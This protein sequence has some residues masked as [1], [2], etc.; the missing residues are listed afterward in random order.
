MPLQMRE[1][2]GFNL[3]IDDARLLTTE[4]TLPPAIDEKIQG[5]VNKARSILENGETCS[6]LSSLEILSM[7]RFSQYW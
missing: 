1:N 6:R 4:S 3:P 2:R 7:A 5:I